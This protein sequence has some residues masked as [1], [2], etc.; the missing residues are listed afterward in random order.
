MKYLFCI[1]L[2]L[3]VA[4]NAHGEEGILAF[5]YN[6]S[7]PTQDF[8]DYIDETSWIGGGFD[9]RWFVSPD[10]PFTLGLAASWHVFD[11][12]LDGTTELPNGAVTGHQH[13]YVN[14]FP[15]VAT[16]HY[17]FGDRSRVWAFIGGGVG[18]YY[19]LQRFEIGVTGLR[20][21]QLALRRVSGARRADPV[22]AG[23]SLPEREIQLRLRRR[24]NRCRG[25]RKRTTTRAFR[26]GSRT[27]SGSPAEWGSRPTRCWRRDRHEGARDEMASG[28]VKR[29][30]QKGTC[31]EVQ[32]GHSRYCP[33]AGRCSV[34]GAVHTRTAEKLEIRLPDAE[35]QGR[36]FGLRRIPVERQSGC[37]VRELFRRNRSEGQFRL[38]Y[39]G[40]YQR[41]PGSPARPSVSPSGH[42]AA[43]SGRYTRTTRSETSPSSTGIS[44]A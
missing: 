19:V 5:H 42:G 20:A 31:D 36:A 7:I 15:I 10:R 33:A 37:L 35:P 32:I 23:G 8:T 25:N 39:R 17:Y 21:G 22:Q 40:R 30:E 4:G 1:A 43:C 11:Q 26:L 18:T 2:L 6:I 3:V 13:R 12:E 29:F 14:S 28:F 27:T 9:G 41:S 24:E 34:L 16:A 44:A 38:G